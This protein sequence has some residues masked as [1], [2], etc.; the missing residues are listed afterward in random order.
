MARL[1][2][3]LASRPFVNAR[4]LVLCTAVAAL[5]LAAFTFLNV[6]WLFGA[7]HES[8][9]L[10]REVAANRAEIDEAR[11]SAAKLAKSIS[12]VDRRRIR[13]VAVTTREIIEKRRLA[14]TR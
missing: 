9:R 14:W 3:N 8:F 6:Y 2:L 1:D 7:W 12:E 4:P 13:A 5:L 10:G 11:T